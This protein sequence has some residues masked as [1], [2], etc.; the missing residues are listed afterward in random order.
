MQADFSLPASIWRTITI[1]FT[2]T[3]PTGG[4]LNTTVCA[5]YLWYM[6]A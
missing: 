5:A 4:A 3:G 1:T 2:L 6:A